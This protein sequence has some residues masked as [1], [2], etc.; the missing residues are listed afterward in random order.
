MTTEAEFIS[1]YGG[2][3]E[4]SQWVAEEAAPDAA[5]TGE[6]DRICHDYI[7]GVQN[8]IPAPLNYRGFPKSICTSVNHVVCHGIPGE[9]KLKNGDAINITIQPAPASKT[10]SLA[11]ADKLSWLIVRQMPNQV[12]TITMVNSTKVIMPA[13]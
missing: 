9:K 11:I 10:S 4:R 12:N 6:L 5:G 3:Y 8:A 13:I 1:R 7:T 2:I